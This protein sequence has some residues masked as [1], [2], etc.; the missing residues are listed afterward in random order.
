MKAI[1]EINKLQAKSKAVDEDKKMKQTRKDDLETEKQ[2][3]KQI[4]YKAIDAGSRLDA[5]TTKEKPH[6]TNAN[7]KKKQ[8]EEAQR[9][10]IDKKR[11]E[12]DE[13][14]R[15]EAKDKERKK[16][17]ESISLRKEPSASSSKHQFDKSRLDSN[18]GHSSSG[19][20]HS[21]SS[22]KDFPA[23]ILTRKENIRPSTPTTKPSP[24]TKPTQVKNAFP[25][26]SKA[27]ATA[28]TSAS[29]A[30][31][32]PP[33]PYLEKDP[34]KYGDSKSV[35]GSKLIAEVREEKNAET[36]ATKGGST[37]G[38]ITTCK[39]YVRPLECKDCNKKQLEVR[40]K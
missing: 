40:K 18:E 3:A 26:S 22:V 39:H 33:P 37:A 8:E 38:G 2:H 34:R 32:P 35:S 21:T 27:A 13:R 6:I 7:Q 23:S 19:S 4:E 11:K 15:A 24:S 5:K 1:A 14:I 20:R 16:L 29:T 12:E 17:Q 30:T 25:A 10:A 28:S 9:K 31:K 36:V